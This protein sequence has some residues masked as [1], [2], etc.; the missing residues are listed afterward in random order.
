MGWQ[1]EIIEM[2]GFL[3]AWYLGREQALD[4]VEEALHPAFSFAGPNGE[5]ADRAT[6]LD[7]IRNGHGH[8][9]QLRITTSDHQLLH[10]TPEVIVAAYVER[11]ELARGDNERLCTVVFTVEDDAPNGLRWLR[12]HES[13]IRRLPDGG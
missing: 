3:E 9:A 13:W 2:Q 11:H 5:S 4:R 7:L 8:T 6:V 10:R 1:H 12:T